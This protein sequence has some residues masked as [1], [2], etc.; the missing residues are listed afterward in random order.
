MMDDIVEEV[1]EEN[2]VQ[3]V[4]FISPAFKAA[5]EMLMAKRTR[6]YWTPCATHCIE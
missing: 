2:V 4:T 6:L 3:V 1:G 5:G